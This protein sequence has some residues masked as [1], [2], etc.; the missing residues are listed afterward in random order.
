V[1]RKFPCVPNLGSRPLPLSLAVV[2]VRNSTPT[3]QHK[4]QSSD[5]CVARTLTL[6]TILKCLSPTGYENDCG[7]FGDVILNVKIRQI[8]VERNDRFEDYTPSSYEV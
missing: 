4:L 1:L 7:G 8:T 3:L 2:A 6:Q 5:R